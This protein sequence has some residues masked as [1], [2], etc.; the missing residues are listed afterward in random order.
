MEKDDTIIVFT[1]TCYAAVMNAC[2]S[3]D[4]HASHILQLKDTDKS[5]RNNRFIDAMLAAYRASEKVPRFSTNGSDIR[6]SLKH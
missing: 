2:Y 4:Y 6:Y 5:R 3:G 1:D